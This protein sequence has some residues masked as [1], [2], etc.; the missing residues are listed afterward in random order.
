MANQRNREFEVMESVTRALREAKSSLDV[1][2]RLMFETL[3]LI[4]SQHAAVLLINAQGEL[5]RESTHGLYAEMESITI[6]RGQ[7]LSW[8][9]LEQH[10]V[11][12]SLDAL[13]E[14]RFFLQL[15]QRDT[16]FAQLIAPMVSSNGEPLGV[17]ISARDGTNGYD[18]LE[19]RL[20]GLIAE[21]ASMALERV[22][23]AE[24][25]WVQVRESRT[26]LEL[27][28]MLERTDP[29]AILTAL[30]RIRELGSADLATVNVLEGDRYQVRFM[31]GQPTPELQA[32][33]QRGL[34][35]DFV[36]GLNLP[37][38]Q[39]VELLDTGDHAAQEVMKR[40][41]V[42][43]TF[44]VRVVTDDQ[45]LS[46]ILYRFQFSVG[47]TPTE[48]SQLVAAAR[49]LGALISRMERLQ[50][51]EAA[52]EGALRTI[53]VA[54]EARDRQTA[55]HTDRVAHLSEQ[56]A[57]LVGL[58]AEQARA[59]RWGAYLHDVGMLIVPDA[60]LHKPGKLE[61]DELEM[62]HEHAQRGYELTLSL[63][64]L[65]DAARDVVRYHHERWDGGGY[66]KRL[67]G[68]EIPLEARIFSVCD[69][70]DTL[71]I[72]RPYKSSMTVAEARRELR[73]AA[74]SGQ[75]EPRLVWAFEQLLDG[76][77]A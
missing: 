48:R 32:G 27:S 55:G 45:Q 43:A 10:E 11:M 20:V 42:T 49:M 31:A 58:S 4:R 30:E 76:A 39:G 59:V 26:L 36:N 62:A 35:H 17:L 56:L 54:I 75:L 1:S 73:N 25:L 69:V 66:P 60:V 74:Q 40:V 77:K 63:P 65:P 50:A 70:F 19:C 67:S 61:P 6:P 68:E 16:P 41:G 34:S 38:E 15:G 7:G 5:Q 44:G 37:F 22:L 8:Q 28:A 33:F 53:G 71:L 29:N 52:H 46:L 24:R 57:R 18:E 23:V 21:T 13:H 51:L 9:A 72:H 12:Y 3:R 47:W 2:E 64:F 14:T